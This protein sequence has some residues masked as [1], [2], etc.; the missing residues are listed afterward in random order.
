MDEKALYDALCSGRVAAA[1]LD[2]MEK[3]P[4]DIGSELLRHPHVIVT[5]HVGGVTADAAE[6]HISWSWIQL[7][8]C[9]ME[10]G[11]PMLRIQRRWSIPAGVT[12]TVN[13][14]IER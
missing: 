8:R 3:E 10:K 13:G 6:G 9:W 11:F 5:P 7:W 12:E 4:F 14:H 1:G 2:V